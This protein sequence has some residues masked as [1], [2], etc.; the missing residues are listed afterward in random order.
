MDKNIFYLKEGRK[1]S[2]GCMFVK[3]EKVT[4]D[5]PNFLIKFEIGLKKGIYIVDTSNV[6]KIKAKGYDLY[7]IENNY[8]EKVLQEHINNCVDEGELKYLE[9]VRKTHLSKS[10]CDSFLIENMCEK[11]YF[12][13]LHI[14]S[15]NNTIDG[16]IK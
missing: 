13:Y 15:F 16:E 4:H 5:V 10:Q 9:R 2:L 7:L 6:D 3:L 8:Q 12:A 1:Y 14:S 11:S